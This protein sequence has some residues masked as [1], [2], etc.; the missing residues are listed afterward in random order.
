MLSTYFINLQLST[1]AWMPRYYLRWRD[2]YLRFL[3]RLWTGGV[4][5]SF[6]CPLLPTAYYPSNQGYYILKAYIFFMNA[7]P[8]I[9]SWHYRSKRSVRRSHFALWTK[10]FG[11]TKVTAL[12]LAWSVM[13]A[14]N[15][16]IRWSYVEFYLLNPLHLF[17][18]FFYRIL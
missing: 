12:T 8:F 16:H 3:Y 6:Y 17:V 4:F 5:D 10:G 7:I 15:V 1:P 13:S 14:E 9:A 2:V 11:G 18:V